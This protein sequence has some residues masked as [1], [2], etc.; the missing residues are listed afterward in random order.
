MFDPDD[1]EEIREATSRGDEE[2]LGR[3]RAT[4]RG[5]TNHLLP[6]IAAA[7]TPATVGEIRGV[8]REAFGEHRPGSAV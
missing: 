4:A 1:L 7:K 5:E 2:T 3:F 6:L 8:P